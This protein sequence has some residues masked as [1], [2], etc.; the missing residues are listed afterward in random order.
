MVSGSASI[1]CVGFRV[2]GLGF[3]V[4]GLQG[5]PNTNVFFTFRARTPKKNGFIFAHRTSIAQG[6]IV[7]LLV[8]V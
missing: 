8:R 1:P 3:M 4:K 2:Y 5:I 7:S 6:I